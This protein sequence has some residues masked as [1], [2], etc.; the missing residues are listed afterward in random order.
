MEITWNVGLENAAKDIVKKVETKK[1]QKDENVYEK[2]LR[3]RQEKKKAKKAEAKAAAKASEQED[4]NE[5]NE[6]GDS[7]KAFCD[8]FFTQG[9]YRCSGVLGLHNSCCPVLLMH[10][11]D[12]VVAPQ[13]AKK[14]ALKRAQQQREEA[15]K[16]LKLERGFDA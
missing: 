16:E 10:K 11:P 8:P 6:D 12:S 3:E 15:E 2:Y 9:I 5:D 13:K 14:R 1:S 4:E 7:A